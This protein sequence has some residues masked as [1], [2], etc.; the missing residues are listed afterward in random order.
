MRDPPET[1]FPKYF[2]MALS[3]ETCVA[4]HTGDRTEQQ[5]RVGIF[6]HASLPG[7]LMAVV[8]DGM[9]GHTGGA[10]AAEQVLLKAKQNFE[11]FTPRDESAEHFLAGIINEAHLVI[12]LTRFTSEQD[13]HSTAAVLLLQPG[14]ADWAHCG[15]SRLY[16]FRDGRLVTRTTDHSLVEELSR[17]GMISA[18][19][20]LS[21]PQRN[22]LMSCLGAEREPRIDHA[23][24]LGLVAGDTFLL[25]SD[26][27]W[28][29]LSEH[30]IG[31]ELNARSARE[32][33]QALISLAR[34]R[35]DGYGDN[36]SV[37]IVRLVEAPAR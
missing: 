9:G 12:K 26:G 1:L 36:I 8:A 28:G 23:S 14:R 24:Q 25:C 3:V 35:S 4:R 27:L 20:A 32:G 7:M 29:D 17:K 16:H 22:V 21:H 13:P 2:Q 31:A 5:D 34:A 19:A 6:G 10:M 30:E 33:A 37:A 18:A 15:D 11:M